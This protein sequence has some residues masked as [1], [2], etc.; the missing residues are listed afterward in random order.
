MNWKKLIQENGSVDIQTLPHYY[1]KFTEKSKIQIVYDYPVVLPI[2]PEDKFIINYGLP[3]E[4]QIFRKTY[5][6]KDLARW[7]K[8]DKDHFIDGEYNRRFNGYWYFIKGERYYITGPF[9]F[10]LNYWTSNTSPYIVY[11]FTDLEFYLIWMHVKYDTKCYGLLDAKCRQIGDTE[12]VIC[13]I[14]EYATRVKKVKCPMQSIDETDI[15]ENAYKRILHAH[16]EMIFYMKATNRGNSDPVDGLFFDYQRETLSKEKLKKNQ[17]EHGVAQIT[18]V[19]YEF[20]PLDSSIV[21]GAT[22]PHVF[23]TG[24]F[25]IYYMDEWGKWILADP[26]YTWNVVKQAMYNKILGEILGKS[27]FTSTVEELKGGETLKTAKKFWRQSDP[28]KRNAAGETLT[29]LY[30]IFRGMLDAAQP[31]H[32]GFPQKEL[33]MAKYK[34]D[35]QSYME[36]GDIK[37]MIEYKR[38]NAITIEDVFQATNEGSQFDIEKLQKRN[39]YILNDAPKSLFVRGNLKWKDGIKDTVVVWEPNSKGRWIISRH[40]NDFGAKANAKVNGIVASKPANAHIF[41]AGID[42]IDQKSVLESDPSLGAICVF[43]KLNEFIDGNEDRYY[44]FNDEEQGIR[45][46]DPVNGGENFITNRVVCTYLFDRKVGSPDP[47]EFFEDTI[48]TLVYFGTDALI[49]KN[50][51]HA[52]VTYMAMRNYDLYKMARPTSFKNYRGQEET[53]GV[54]ATEGNIDAYFSFLT[55]LSCKWWNTIDH[56]DL[57]EQLLSMNYAN[58]GK[59]DLGV[60]CGWAI[61]ASTVPTNRMIHREEQAK[62]VHYTENYV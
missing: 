48:M 4:D 31:D 14:Y 40:P 18:N 45:M 1:I 30:R 8:K 46:G 56:P 13:I 25:G 3:I 34:S 55:T 43:A 27:I 5:I 32:W 28:E 44:Q 20:P 24:T 11:R 57:L 19:E 39:Y 33:A 26:L 7:A 42:P 6:P 49:E 12:K 37:G 38:M 51:Q 60:A 62:I 58:K 16:G 10:F 21:Y 41:C 23:G 50:R 29:G 59:K 9:Y 22:K 35:I 47:T 17:A 36:A 52:L 54:S 2:P 53:D 15:Y 61:Y